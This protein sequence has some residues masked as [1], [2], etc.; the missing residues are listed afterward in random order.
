MNIFILYE[1]KS[2]SHSQTL[3]NEWE[4]LGTRLTPLNFSCMVIVS[5]D[6]EGKKEYIQLLAYNYL[7]AIVTM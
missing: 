4:M 3:S 2:E 6:Y 7:V 1:Q 5:I